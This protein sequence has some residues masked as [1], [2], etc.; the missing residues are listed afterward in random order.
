MFMSS[1]GAC[2]LTDRTAEKLN[3]L[4]AELNP[5]SVTLLTD[6]NTAQHCLPLLATELP[7]FSQITVPAGEQNKNLGG[8]TEIWKKM[9]DLQI[10]RKGLLIVLGGGV[11]GDMGGFCAS[12]YKRG[13]NFILIPTTLLAQVDASVGGKLGIDF[14]DFKNHIGVFQNPVA[15]IIDSRFLKTV[16]GGELRSGFAEIIKHCIISDAVMFEKISGKDLESQ[17]LEE[18]VAHSVA[19]KKDVVTKDPKESGLRKILNFGH[20]IGHGIESLSLGSSHRFLHGEAIAIGMITES[21]IACQKNMISSDEL[22]QI[23]RF[24]KQIFGKET[25]PA[26]TGD[27]IR[28]IS[29]DKKNRGNKILMALPDGIGQCKWDVDVTPEEIRAS[30]EY[31]LSA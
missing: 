29:Q 10:D 14:E 20:T 9:T 13:I 27:L 18:L 22:N 19:F 8:A 26:A 21:W 31:Y 15:T 7:A 23:T 4:I 6:E 25:I 2:I 5:S 3:A 24:I 30:L 11:L 17:Q 1:A 28:V 12:T 16:P